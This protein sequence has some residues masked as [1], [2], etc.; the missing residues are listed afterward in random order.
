MALGTAKRGNG[1]TTVRKALRL[2][3]YLASSTAP[4]GMSDLARRTSLDKATTHRLLS[5]LTEAGL[6]RQDGTDKRY[7]LGLRLAYF[8]ACALD[9]LDI[10]HIALPV[11]T[12]L[13]EVTGQTVHLGCLDGAEVVFLNKVEGKESISLRSRVGA[14]APVHATALGKC[15][16]AFMPLADRQTLLATL[17]LV[18]LTSRT[19]TN[20]EVFERHL[21]EVLRLRYA[22]DDEEHV[23]SICCIAAPIFDSKGY[24]TAAISITGP[25]FRITTALVPYLARCVIQAAQEI[26]ELLGFRSI[27]IDGG[28]PSDKP[29][30]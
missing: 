16:L 26:S 1:T 2:L 10:R 24:P 11:M 22:V 28:A 30:C 3:E 9:R 4:I 14:R 23:E 20:L 7:A 15:C 21:E 29:G 17:P 27:P 12:K 5:V 25:T 6:V 18:K 8:G 19:I 13:M